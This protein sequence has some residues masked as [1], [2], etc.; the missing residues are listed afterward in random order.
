ME[1]GNQVSS[2]RFIFG[3]GT[4]WLAEEMENHGVAYRTRYRVVHVTNSVHLLHLCRYIHA[5]PVIDEFVE[6]LD[7]WPYSNYLDW[8]GKRAGTLVDRAFIC[9]HF[10][11]PEQYTWY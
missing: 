11:T 1:G 6:G 7:D 5:N 8:V 4:G 10:P 3:I 2:G 9:K